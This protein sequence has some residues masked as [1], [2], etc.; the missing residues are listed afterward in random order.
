MPCINTHI[1]SDNIVNDYQLSYNII[2]SR[3]NKLLP[4]TIII[5]PIRFQKT[6]FFYIS[7][8]FE[9]YF[10]YTIFTQD[11]YPADTLCFYS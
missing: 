4:F 1:K 10:E 11:H 8:E 6:F 9:L 5:G 7:L 3:K 2:K